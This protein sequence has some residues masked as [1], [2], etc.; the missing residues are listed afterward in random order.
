MK[1]I[2]RFSSF[3][4]KISVFRL[5]GGVVFDNFIKSMNK[6]GVKK[7]QNTMDKRSKIISIH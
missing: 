3:N 1:G 2:F 7:T 4:C 6:L 5:D